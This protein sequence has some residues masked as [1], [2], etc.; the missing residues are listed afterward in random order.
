M[1]RTQRPSFLK[2]QKEQ[3]S[4]LKAI[5]K[6]DRVLTSGGIYGTVVGVDDTKTVVRVADDVKLVPAIA[7][8][9][10][11]ELGVQ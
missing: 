3:Q 8:H 5:K 1:P 4:M 9:V 11:E 6:G 10:A 7:R 2:R